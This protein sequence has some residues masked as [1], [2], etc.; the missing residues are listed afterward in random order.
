MIRKILINI[1]RVLF[2]GVFIF[3][4][5]V[6]VIDPLGFTY[7]IED[8]LEAF[9]SF[10]SMFSVFAFPVS[11]F[12][13]I[14]E[15]IIG[16]NILFG[17]Y[18]KKTTILA[19]LFMAVMLPLTLYVAI[20]DPV[21]DCGC[22]GDALVISNWATFTKNIF[23]SAFAVLLF[24]FRK[25][26]T[27]LFSKKRR[28]MATA[29]ASIFMLLLSLYCYWYLPII[30]F[31]PYK[32]GSNIEEGM[33]IPEGEPLDEYKTIYVYE[34][35]GIPK[36][37]ELQGMDMV[38]LE[39]GN[40]IDFTTFSKDW[41]FISQDSKLVKKGYTP[42]IHDFSIVTQ[43]EGDITENVL[44]D[45]N[46]TFLLIS[47]DLQKA[48]KRH[49]TDIHK[50]YDYAVENGYKFY[51][52]TSSTQGDI[53]NYVQETGAKYPIAQADGKM[54]K[55]IIRSNPGLLLIKNA[56][57]YNMWDRNDLP[58]FDKPLADSEYGKIATPTPTKNTLIAGLLLFVPV[59]ILLLIDK[60]KNKKN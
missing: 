60:R 38:D 7:K 57:V 8:Y 55:T 13:S 41:K 53:R 1:I 20:F 51:S 43:E 2:A 10:F 21:T 30:D 54:L 28:W 9:G 27:P 47:Y 17:I 11:I 59:I 22:F 45:S 34:K 16:F 44:Q 4:G 36:E 40:K 50:I 12:M 48:S 31:R 56:T 23:F 37:F 32:I 19:M 25:D 26:I 15:F 18:R 14:L 58:I 24:I 46:Y 6:K 5:F 42:P 3:S 52:M 39:S 35:N 29:Y 49:V 33:K